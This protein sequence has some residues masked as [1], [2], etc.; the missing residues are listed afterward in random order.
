MED[1]IDDEMLPQQSIETDKAIA[2]GEVS[3]LMPEPEHG[4]GHEPKTGIPWLDGIIAVSVIFISVLSLAV[5]IEHG[6]SMEKMVD[7][8]QKMVVASTLPLLTVGGGQLDPV[9]YK[10]MS[11]LVL[12]NNG[13]GPA[14]IETF[15]IRYKGVAQTPDTF[16]K[17]CCA[18]ALGKGGDR[19]GF[20]YSNV[21]G[22][23]LPARETRDLITIRPIGSD[24][25]LL[26]AY[27]DARKD[28]SFHACYC[29]VLEECWEVDSDQHQKRPQLVKEC[30]VAP[31]EKLW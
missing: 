16:L 17:A 19:S 29:S 1:G 28:M 25:K 23:I 11:R 12:A 14:I 20:I 31:G 27:E 24:Y 21:S 10:P 13:V 4:H 7:Q 2:E 22:A 30:K 8:N 26:Q 9:T 18:Q 15:E 3:G 5:S 6:R